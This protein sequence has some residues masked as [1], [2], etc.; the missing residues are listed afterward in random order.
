[1]KLDKIDDNT[2]NLLEKY[3]KVSKQGEYV[4]I[5]SPSVS[6][7][8][9]VKVLVEKGLSVLEIKYEERS[10]EDFFFSLLKSR[11]E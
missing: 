6:S 4:V 10:L 1:I 11:G 7:G 5:S 3:G 8:E 2:V 9:V